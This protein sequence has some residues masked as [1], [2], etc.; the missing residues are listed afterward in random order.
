[1][2]TEGVTEGLSSAGS[3]GLGKVLDA[4]KRGIQG[5]KNRVPGGSRG[6]KATVG[7]PNSGQG[8][9]RNGYNPKPGERTLKGYVEQTA[10]PEISLYTE[11]AGYN[12]NNGNTG[13]QFKRL[14]AESGHG[15]NGPHVH[16]PLRNVA[17]DGSV[18]G[19]VGSKTKNGGVTS[20]TVKDVKQL[21]EYI[22]NGKYHQKN[23]KIVGGL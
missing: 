15:I 19:D 4:V 7:R 18:F 13:G 9:S 22:N 23:R 10:N 11:S 20:P 17:P 8:Y 6:G 3:F 1:M 21:Y 2:L 5:R 14:G 12:N 16:Q